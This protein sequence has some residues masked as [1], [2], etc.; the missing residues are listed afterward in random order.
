MIDDAPGSHRDRQSRTDFIRANTRLCSPGLIPEIRLHLADESLAIWEKTEAELAELNLPPPYWAF[1]WVGGQALAR[2]VLDNPE[3][4]AGKR[5]LD[6]GSGSG[7]VAIAAMR[8]GALFARAA[9]IDPYSSIAASLNAHANLVALDIVES[10]LLNTTPAGFDVLLVGDLFY[11][12]ATAERVLAFIDRIS[13]T[14]TTVLAGDPRRSYFPVARF[15]T[16][17]HYDV[18]TTRELEDADTKSAAVWRLK[19]V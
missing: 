8:A 17:A 6:L 18:V 15:E 10:D 13:A 12:R 4:V 11:E 19:P 2:Y 16:V 5:V 14:G 9:D 7:L 1:A 3:V